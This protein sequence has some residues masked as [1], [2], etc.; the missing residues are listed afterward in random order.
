MVVGLMPM[1]LDKDRA[2]HLP[3]F[4]EFLQTACKEQRITLDQWESFLQFNN[5]INV[6]LSNFEDDG[7]CKCSHLH[8]PTH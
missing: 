8:Q 1:I 5:S 3:Y 2:P 6:D 7:A 4:L